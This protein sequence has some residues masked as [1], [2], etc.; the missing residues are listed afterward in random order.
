MRLFL[1]YSTPDLPVAERLADA[2]A[3]HRPELTVYFAPRRNRAG[4]YWMPVLGEEL[5][6]SDTVLL[7][8]GKW[9]GPWQELEYYEALRLWR[10]TGRP[11][12]VPAIVAETVPGLHF[13]D[14]FHCLFLDGQAIGSAIAA[15]LA[16]LDRAPGAD[17]TADWQVTNPYRGL[18]AMGTEDAAFFF[19]REA[20][21]VSI[22]DAIH[23]TPNRVLALVGNSGVGKSSVARAGVIASLRSQ[24]WPGDLN[25]PWPEYLSDSAYWLAIEVVPGERPLLS[26]VRAFTD[27]WLESPSDSFREAI[28]WVE[29]FQSG[30]R[31]IGLAELAQAAAHR[32][33]ERNYGPRPSRFFLY[34]DQG[35]ELYS[36]ALAAEAQ[37]FS[38][39]V[40]EAVECPEVVVLMSIRSDW[41][42]SLQAD[43][44]LFAAS[45]RI[46]VP[47]LTLD[48]I[49]DIVRKPAARL[50]ARFDNA[51]IVPLIAEAAAREPG[52]LPMLSYL[53]EDAWK[54][55]QADPQSKGALRFPFEVV[56]VSRPLA[57]RAERFF[58]RHPNQV[59]VIRRLFTLRLAHV[60]SNGRP[61][62][63]RAHEGECSPEEWALAIE[64]TGKDW[65]LLA[66]G[67]ESG[68]AVVEVA[69]E[70]ILEN[71]PRLATWIEEKRGFLASKGQLEIARREWEKADA[72]RKERALLMGLALERA[73]E[74]MEEGR[75]GDLS[76]EDRAFVEASVAGDEA[77]ARAAENRRRMLTWSAVAASV[78]LA[79]IATFAVAQW[80]EAENERDRAETSYQAALDATDTFLTALTENFTDSAALP[81]EK[82]KAILS[83]GEV[84]LA[85]M[86]TRIGASPALHQVRA[87]VLTQFAGI[88]ANDDINSARAQLASALNS[89][90][91]L[92]AGDPT[93]KLVEAEILTHNAVIAK[94]E[95]DHE[96][97]H[98]YAT[99]AVE[100][101]I[102]IPAGTSDVNLTLAKAY[103]LKAASERLLRRYEDS[104]ASSDLCLEALRPIEDIDVSRRLFQL[105]TCLHFKALAMTEG[106]IGNYNADA[107]SLYAAE[108]EVL[109]GLIERDPS[110]V[111]YRVRLAMIFNNLANVGAAALDKEQTLARRQ[112]ARDYLNQARA[113]APWSAE[114]NEWLAH[115]SLWVGQQ[116]VELGRR[117]EAFAAHREAAALLRALISKDPENV[118]WLNRYEQTLAAIR[119]N[120][121]SL[122]KV[123]L[124]SDQIETA[125]EI[126]R[127]HVSLRE[128]PTKSEMVSDYYAGSLLESRFRLAEALSWNGHVIEA[129][130]AYVAVISQA[131][132]AVGVDLEDKWPRHFV[133]RA[134]WQYPRCEL[135]MGLDIT[136]D[137]KI[138]NCEKALA[139]RGSYLERENHWGVRAV[140]AEDRHTLGLLLFD[141][142]RDEEALDHVE[143]A[144]SRN[145]IAAIRTLEAWYRTGEGPVATD[146]SKAEALANRVSKEPSGMKTFTV[147]S[148][149]FDG[150]TRY[151]AQFYARNPTDFAPEPVEEEIERLE[152]IEVFILPEDFKDHVRKVLNIAR[153]HGVSFVDLYVYAVSS[154]GAKKENGVP[155]DQADLQKAMIVALQGRDFGGLLAAVEPFLKTEGRRDVVDAVVADLA[156]PPEKGPLN[157]AGIHYLKER[158]LGIYGAGGYELAELAADAFIEIASDLSDRTTWL[159]R[160]GI[161]RSAGGLQNAAIADLTTVV[162]SF[163]DFARG[164]DALAYAYLL[165]ETEYDRA[166]LLAA[167]A[168]QISPEDIFIK[169]TLGLAQVKTN[170]LDAAINTL[171]SVIEVDDKLAKPWAHLAE[172][173]RRAGRYPEAREAAVRARALTSEPRLLDYIALQTHLIDTAAA[174]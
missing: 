131:D 57:E 44:P 59:D 28:G 10:K 133:S 25:H 36:R 8:M 55:M 109:R 12:I 89:L 158:W 147:P 136:R 101:A 37:R 99:R 35:E 97:M 161:A 95:Q 165:A 129:A 48:G 156:R 123:G 80:V 83:S 51:D 168:S 79:M 110:N 145:V 78:V 60:P 160:R 84:F 105:A 85:D 148:L 40:A 1:S 119:E 153:E 142:G 54:A 104:M 126:F 112:E 111:R 125:I 13:L 62:R 47:P 4:A 9:I 107:P 31:Q 29:H 21:T 139:L 150:V 140:I 49:K 61:V 33:A 171:T 96:Q 141:A 65:R 22:L 90:A 41:Y 121:A 137:E 32:I 68:E 72:N 66:S 155:Q 56:D 102:R 42:G 114:V 46:D 118:G 16:A 26:L 50:G 91:A 144:V 106:K 146:P 149:L 162:A 98:A 11:L 115:T 132:Y 172:A 63:R 86:E 130:K 173:Y 87:K 2:L 116:L 18:N 124:H 73:R 7:L 76:P 138:R 23:T 127:E 122:G 128:L 71:W 143:F 64:L 17:E 75:A 14:H 151:P 157:P 166:L 77:L 52:S 27:L 159:F 6:A 113:I 15:I 167:R 152:R 88:T 100:A 163:P 38:E 5:A 81:A 3:A 92:P 45:T 93:T 20:L 94:S 43:G 154:A 53:M 58:A 67:E 24:L 108:E 169:N 69:H 30:N 82:V 164:I 34:V 170:N 134:Y 135:Y 70:K 174:R 117:Q 120:V 103:E 39:L 74:W 19:G